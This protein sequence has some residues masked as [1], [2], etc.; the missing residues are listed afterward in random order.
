MMGGSTEWRAKNLAKGESVL[1]KTGYMD[2]GRGYRDF[3]LCVVATV[4]VSLTLKMHYSIQQSVFIV[5][6]HV[7]YSKYDLSL[8]N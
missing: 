4:S 6:E 8:L 7:K 1:V 5:E 2:H 3:D